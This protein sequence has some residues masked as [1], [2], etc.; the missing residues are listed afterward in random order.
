MTM[1]FSRQRVLAAVLSLGLLATSC[2]SDEPPTRAEFVE[3]TLSISSNIGDGNRDSWE[4]SYGCLWDDNI[5]R[6]EDLIV[7]MMKWDDFE[8]HDSE[9]WDEANA[10]LGA[11]LTAGAGE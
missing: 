4:R 8:Q 9:Y 10:A 2:G 1:Y 3:H 7:E 6:N 5:E 11:C